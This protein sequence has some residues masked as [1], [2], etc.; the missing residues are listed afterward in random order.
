MAR[1]GEKK[2]KIEM[3]L[4]KVRE[5]LLEKDGDLRIRTPVRINGGQVVI[6]KYT[7][8]GGNTRCGLR[9]EPQ[10][11][12]RNAMTLTNE[13]HKEFLE[14]IAKNIE[15]LEKIMDVIVSVNEELEALETTETIDVDQLLREIE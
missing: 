5:I 13:E 7:T 12:F 3:Y 9:F 6:V 4:N 15:I 10:G 8:R 11:S 14:T 2:E 1:S